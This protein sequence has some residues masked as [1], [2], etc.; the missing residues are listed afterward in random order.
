MNLR[1]TAILFALCVVVT[2]VVNRAERDRD[3]WFQ[4]DEDQPFEFP[5]ISLRRVEVDRPQGRLVLERGEERWELREPFSFPASYARTEQ[6]CELLR[7]LRVRGSVD[8]DGAEYGATETSTRASFFV[9][10]IRYQLLFGDPH[11]EFP[12]VYTVLRE[13]SDSSRVV[14][15]DAQIKGAFENVTFE[16]LRDDA[17]CRINSARAGRVAIRDRRSA[18]AGIEVHLERDADGWFVREPY[19]SPADLGEVRQLV[20]VLNSWAIEEFVADGLDPF[21]AGNP[22]GLDNPRWEIDVESRDGKRR[23]EIVIGDAGPDDEEGGPRVYVARQG[24]RSVFL[25]SAKLLRLIDRGADVYRDRFLFLLPAPE[26]QRVELD[27]PEGISRSSERLVLLIDEETGQWSL[28]TGDGLSYPVDPTWLLSLTEE[29]RA[30]EAR[31]FIP[32]QP[33]ERSDLARFGLDKPLRIRLV[34]REGE[35]DEI[36]IGKD[37]PGREGERYIFNARWA[38]HCVT[39]E[40][41]AEALLREVPWSLRS[42]V[43][44]K[45][46]PAKL[47]EFSLRVPGTSTPAGDLDSR[48]KVFVRP[49]RTWFEKGRG[50]DPLAPAEI[51]PLIHFMSFLKARRW[52]PEPAS[53]PGPDRY[54]LRL[55]ILELRDSSETVPRVFYF[56]DSGAGI[57]TVR[58]GDDGWV[59]QVRMEAGAALPLELARALMQ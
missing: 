53:P 58:D 23:A 5:L 39:S 26:L 59:F 57:L 42:T 51:E 27:V 29:F 54:D 15:V 33:E 12:Y 1:T 19:Q 9:G 30:S 45:C 7:E 18:E 32:L 44:F 43:V 20:E 2:W 24:G 10:A 49:H 4:R 47:F 36:L 31:S 6:L 28:D 22:Y 38:D 56:S 55:E 25:A 17:I 48:E 46:D 34:P 3:F 41:P 13:G 14:L 37:V 40:I 52:L 8:G 50:S 16:A 11:P 21:A 35:A